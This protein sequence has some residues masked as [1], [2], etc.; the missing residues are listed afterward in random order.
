[1][2]AGYYYTA[3]MTPGT[4]E[5]V[6]YD[7]VMRNIRFNHVA[8]VVEGRAGSDV[9]VGDSME[10][11]TMNRNKH[12]SR[13]AAMAKGA[14]VACLQPRLAQDA[15]LDIAPLMVG[16]KHSNW[17]EA[18]GK[19]IAG[20][21]KTN[22][23]MFKDKPAMD[24]GLEDVV[25]LLDSLDGEDPDT[26][27]DA[28]GPDANQEGA[29]AETTGTGKGEDS[30]VEAVLQMLKGKISDEDLAQVAELLKGAAGDDA[31]GDDDVEQFIAKIM[32]AL[33]KGGGEP[34]GEDEDLEAGKGGTEGAG[35]EKVEGVGKAAMD[36]A[37]KRTKGESVAAA[38]AATVKH[39]SDLHEAER[40]VKP[41]V[42]EVLGMDSASSV[43]RM[44]LDQKGVDVKGVHPSA[45]KS[46]VQMLL[47]KGGNTEGG[48][49]QGNKA[50]MAADAAATSRFKE[51]F[52]E[53][54]AVK[55]LG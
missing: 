43:Y 4:Y 38:V 52:P 27:E 12:M 10:N 53:A 50:K 46:M 39:L 34:G 23:K 21:R 20:L 41:L 40:I 5:G 55:Q 29:N 31:D 48:A 45:Y 19:I 35:K 15:K 11:L 9:V 25:K 44:A 18:K 32:A 37:L 13:K 42:G 6:A 2:S 36:A 28:E 47:A 3:D 16:V 30:P 8:L 33:G 54:G 1:L 14:I 49:H 51:M 26:A 22:V 24:A 7:G 17:G